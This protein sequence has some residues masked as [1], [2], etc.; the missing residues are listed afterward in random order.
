MGAQL[1]LES[2]VKTGNTAGDGTTTATVL[3]HVDLSR[4]DEAGRGGLSPA[5]AQARHRHRRRARRR[6]AREDV[7]AR[8]GEA[9]HR[10]GRDHQRQRRRDD[11]QADRRGGRQG[12]PGRDHSRRAG[13]GAGDQAGGRGGR[14]DRA[15]L[16]VGLLRHRHGAAGRAAR[17]PVHP[18]VPETRSAR[19]PSWCRS[20]RRSRRPGAR[21]WS[22]RRSP[23]RR[24]RCWSSTSCRATMKV[25]AIMA[26][27]L[28]RVAQGGAA[29]SRGA[30]RRPRSSATSRGSR[31]P[32]RRWRIS[33]APR[34]SSSIRRRRPSS[35]ARPTRRSWRRACDEIRA[36]Y[37]DTNSTFR[38]QQ[39]EERLRRLVGGAALIRVGGTTDAETRERKLRIED[40]LFATRAAIEEGIVAGRRRGAGARG[41]RAREARRRTLRRSERPASRSCG[42]RARSRAARSPRTPA[43]IAR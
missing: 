32:R 24:C 39:L 22:S 8:D 34:R 37:A 16:F 26:A 5:R 14:R 11:R 6:G 1:V 27:L 42:G 7:E 12:G 13:D 15:R 28:R 9:R 41:R 36:L 18:A 2:A 3:A 33:G 43:A 29:R 10:E 4:G 30:D 35:A 17:R 38:H 25:C 40:A 20:S 23:A 19:S 21:C 31:S